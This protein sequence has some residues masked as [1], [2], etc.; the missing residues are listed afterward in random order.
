MFLFLIFVFSVWTYKYVCF[1]QGW[2]VYFEIFII[3]IVFV[4]M[5]NGGFSHAYVILHQYF[6][7]HIKTHKMFK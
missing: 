6:G 3:S 5:I 4:P 2:F 7:L 1:Y